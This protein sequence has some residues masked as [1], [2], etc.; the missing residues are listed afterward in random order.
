MRPSNRRKRTVFLPDEMVDEMKR[1]AGRRD[2]PLSQVVQWAIKVAL[3]KMKRLPTARRVS[4]PPRRA[5]MLTLL[6]LVVACGGSA[7]T[8]P[9]TPDA[10]LSATP[11]DT[12][13][14]AAL[15]Q[16]GSD[17]YLWTAPTCAEILAEN[18]VGSTV[19]TWL[20]YGIDSTLTHTLADGQTL[21]VTIHTREVT[22]GNAVLVCVRVNGGA[23]QD[24]ANVI[25]APGD[26]VQEVWTQQF[27]C[28][29]GYTSPL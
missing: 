23:C 14:I 19:T 18:G 22:L 13:E 7:A 12:L 2:R 4:T 8:A 21:T 5:V 25:T 6:L 28:H 27:S 24:P 1:E 20:L 17:P 3:P 26:T 9:R 15:T 11:G 29:T 10:T 16:S